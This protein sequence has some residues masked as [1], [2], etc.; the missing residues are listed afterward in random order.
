L[1]GES[2]FERRF[3]GRL[4]ETFPGCIIIKNDSSY[5]QGIPDRTIFWGPHW[6]TLE[7][8]KDRRARRQPNQEHYV[9]QMAD[10]SF[11]AFVYPENEEEVLVA[12]QEAFAS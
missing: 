2:R 10:M 7:F 4:R 11:S 9:K 5:I 1:A 8:K 3:L 12:L 6:A